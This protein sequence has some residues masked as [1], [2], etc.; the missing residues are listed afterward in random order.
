LI[1]DRQ[2]PA[3]EENEQSH[4]LAPEAA[5][6]VQTVLDD[7]DDEFY[8]WTA[9]DSAL[10]FPALCSSHTPVPILAGRMQLD[11]KGCKKRHSAALAFLAPGYPGAATFQHKDLTDANNC[12]TRF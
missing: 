4:Q 5:Q 6:A 8:C 3:E 11:L 9:F 2:L 12:C 10:G 1:S 7:G